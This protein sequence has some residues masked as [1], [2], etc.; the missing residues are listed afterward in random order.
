MFYEVPARVMKDAFELFEQ[1]VEMP[2]E[3]QFSVVSERAADLDTTL[4]VMVLVAADAKATENR[5]FEVLSG[6]IQWQ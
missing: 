1:V 2:R 6:Q 5:L 3:E 4:A